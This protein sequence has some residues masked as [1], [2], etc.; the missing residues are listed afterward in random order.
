MKHGRDPNT[1][2]NLLFG[3]QKDGQTIDQYKTEMIRN[4][5]RAFEIVNNFNILNKQKYG[6]KINKTKKLHPYQVG[7]KVLL[8]TNQRYKGL[9]P[10]LQ[11][12][13]HGPFE[14]LELT[15]LVNVRI[16]LVGIKRPSFIVHVSRIKRYKDQMQVEK[17]ISHK[18]I[19]TEP[20]N[21]KSNTESN[22]EFEV[23]QILRKR[24]LK[25]G[26]TEYKVKWKGY[27]KRDSTWEPIENLVHCEQKL[28]E[29]ENQYN[30]NKCME[31]DYTAINGKDMYQHRKYHE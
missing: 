9:T 15:S 18:E 11:K 10:K 23:D 14:I 12:V 8:Y 2:M 22:N 7:D 24:T 31:C 13:W 6:L 20:N 25:G 5:S 21:T 27:N 30:N 16:Q 1:S 29:F 17:E 19:I 26:I 28:K 4:L 3:S